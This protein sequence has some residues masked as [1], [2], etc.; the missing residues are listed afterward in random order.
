MNRNVLQ[1]VVIHTTATPEDRWVSKEEVIRWH[2]APKPYGWGWSRPGYNYLILLDGEMPSEQDFYR[3]NPKSIVRVLIPHNFDKYID[4][5]EISFNAGPAYNPISLSVCY[6]GGMD[7]N[8]KNPKDTRN[9]K[10]IKAMNYLIRYIYE[11]YSSMNHNIKFIGHNQIDNKACPSFFAPCY[12]RSIGIPENY[13]DSRD[14][15]GYQR[16]FKTLYRRD[17]Y[18]AV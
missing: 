15:F 6:V 5:G 12:L 14:P 13:I 18:G 17:C 7:K 1:Y 4:I 16:Y 11:R 3:D 9:E 8:Y 2:T 10:Q